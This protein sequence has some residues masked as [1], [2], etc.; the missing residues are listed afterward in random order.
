MPRTTEQDVTDIFD[1]SLDGVSLSAW[2]DVANELVNDIADKDP[3][4]G[5]SRLEKLETLVAAHFAASQDQRHESNS[6][7]ARSVSYQGD[8]GM[9][10]EGTK[11][12]QVALTLDP[13]GT[14]ANAHKP[15]AS[16]SVPD[17]K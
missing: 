12:G 15:S 6:G 17:V 3:S 9:G 4:L 8:T 16:V 1:T 10:F 2:I 14:L 5:A 7:G 13:T 11:H